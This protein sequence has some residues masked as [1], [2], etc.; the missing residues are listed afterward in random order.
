MIAQD[1][2]RQATRKNKSY[3]EINQDRWHLEV[4]QRQG[5]LSSKDQLQ[6][7]L[8]E[9]KIDDSRVEHRLCHELPNDFEN[10]CPFASENS[11]SI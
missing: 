1:Q 5:N 6:K 7:D 4:V 10:V 9:G 2:G 11:F 3:D 8:V